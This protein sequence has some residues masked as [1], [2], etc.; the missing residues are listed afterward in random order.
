MTDSKISAAVIGEQVTD[1]ALHCQL[2][3]RFIFTTLL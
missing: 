2:A 3:D 1:C